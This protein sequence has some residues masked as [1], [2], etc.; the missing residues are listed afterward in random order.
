MFLKRKSSSLNQSFLKRF[1]VVLCF[2]YI[3]SWTHG[4]KESEVVNL[5]MLEHFF[6]KYPRQRF[7][8]TWCKYT[9]WH[10]LYIIIILHRLPVKTV[11]SGSMVL[12]RLCRVTALYSYSRARFPGFYLKP[13]YDCF[14]CISHEFI[15]SCYYFY[16]LF[17]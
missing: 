4:N 2:I 17:I 10:L 8:A 13:V 3:S 11:Q 6:W 1:H 12:T 16:I 7:P 14:S 5:I 15:L 9:V